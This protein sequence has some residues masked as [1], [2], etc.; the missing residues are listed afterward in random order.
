MNTLGKGK[1]KDGRRDAERSDGS[2]RMESGSALSG[3]EFTEQKAKQ[4]EEDSSNDDDN[5]NNYD[6]DNSDTIS[7]PATPPEY[8]LRTPSKRS[9]TQT[10]RAGMV[11]YM[12]EENNSGDEV[13][14]LLS[15]YGSE[16]VADSVNDPEGSEE[17]EDLKDCCA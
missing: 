10:P 8:D 12:G 6:C 2:L 15:P 16:F 14:R 7:L 17:M 9:R 5:N 3:G 4:E 11:P 1:G 13:A